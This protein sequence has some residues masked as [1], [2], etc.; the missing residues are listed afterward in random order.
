M[1]SVTFKLRDCERN[2]EYQAA[3]I[4]GVLCSM[5]THKLK[6]VISEQQFKCSLPCKSN[7]TER[8]DSDANVTR[9]SEKAILRK[10]E[11]LADVSLRATEQLI[12]SV[13][14]YTHRLS[15]CYERM[16]TF[17]DFNLMVPLPS[18]YH[19]SLRNIDELSQ[20]TG[21]IPPGILAE[22]SFWYLRDMNIT[23]AFS[24]NR[25]GVARNKKRLAVDLRCRAL[26]NTSLTPLNFQME[27]LH[28]CPNQNIQLSGSVPVRLVDNGFEKELSQRWY[29]KSFNS[30]RREG[31]LDSGEMKF[32]LRIEE[33][34]PPI[35]TESD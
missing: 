18:S 14:P 2:L 29:V 32:H 24:I 6:P 10:L 1:E 23:V 16:G 28:E 4:A 33:I 25:S 19:L 34:S 35:E 9:R 17:S 7:T 15:A 3:E 27:L 30:L 20:T 13:Q 31:F 12:C 5:V 8:G 22:V 11:I 26:L 21:K